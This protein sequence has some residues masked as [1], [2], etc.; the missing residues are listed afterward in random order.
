MWECAKPQISSCL[1]GNK[2]TILISVNEE[3]ATEGVLLII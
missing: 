1:F 3:D 2:N